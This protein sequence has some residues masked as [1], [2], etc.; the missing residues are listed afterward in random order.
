[1]F[2]LDTFGDQTSFMILVPDLVPEMLAPYP[3]VGVCYSVYKIE[4]PIYIYVYIYIYMAV[5]ILYPQGKMPL[6]GDEGNISGTKILKSFL[7]TKWVQNK[8]YGV[9]LGQ[10]GAKF[11]C[12][13]LSF[14][15]KHNICSFPSQDT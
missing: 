8:H 15:K 10:I 3:S 9:K 2:V 13:S 4:T 14:S 1:M 5:S 7:V 11:Q 12:A 6:D